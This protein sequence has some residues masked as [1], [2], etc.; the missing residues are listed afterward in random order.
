MHEK[1]TTSPPLIEWDAQSFAVGIPDMDETHRHFVDLLNRL[2]N[3]VNKKKVQ[4][5]NLNC[6]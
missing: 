1:Q 6:R 3:T 2:D 4:K 5:M